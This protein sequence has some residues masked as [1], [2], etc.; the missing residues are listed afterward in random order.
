M[1]ILYTVDLGFDFNSIELG[2]PYDQ[3]TGFYPLQFNMINPNGEIAAWPTQ[4]H[5][6]DQ[7]RFHITDITHS[8]TDTPDDVANTWS[9]TGAVGGYTPSNLY[10]AIVNPV[11]GVSPSV[12]PFTSG[13]YVPLG[14]SGVKGLHFDSS[15]LKFQ[16]GRTDSVVYDADNSGWELARW[17]AGGGQSFT[18]QLNVS[19]FYKFSLQLEVSQPSGP[20]KKFIVDPEM[21]VGGGSG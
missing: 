3:S 8:A 18:F 5:S 15:Q 14:S 20:V 10:V 13:S 9:S 21:F 11:T 17:Y 7:I 19:A 16:S 1:S 6:G 2:A 12:N 4:L